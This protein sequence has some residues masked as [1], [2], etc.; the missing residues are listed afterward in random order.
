MLLDIFL[1]ILLFVIIAID[2][3]IGVW[4]DYSSESVNTKFKGKMYP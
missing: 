2:I 3:V 4:F 1:A